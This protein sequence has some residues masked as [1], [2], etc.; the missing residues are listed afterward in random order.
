MTYMSVDKKV[1]AGKLRLVLLEK[2]G[3]AIVTGD[4]PEDV[5]FDTI[6]Y[7]HALFKSSP[8]TY[9]HSLAGLPE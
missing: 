9:E 4:F 1:V 6:M 2:P 3:K 5:L 8:G 7:Y